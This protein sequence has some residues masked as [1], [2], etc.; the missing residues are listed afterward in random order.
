MAGVESHVTDQFSILEQER[1]GLEITPLPGLH[2]ICG[3][4]SPSASGILPGR[5][6]RAL[7]IN[8]IKLWLSTRI[9]LDV[10]GLATRM[11]DMPVSRILCTTTTTT[12]V[13]SLDVC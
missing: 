4:R 3:T 11:T 5:M 9:Y 2:I 12:E 13:W 1:V 6:S 7:R 10:V 8:L